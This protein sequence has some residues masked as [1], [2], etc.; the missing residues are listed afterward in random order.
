[1]SI[2]RSVELDHLPRRG[3]NINWIK[4]VGY[5][6]N[7]TYDDKT[8]LINILDYNPS[9]KKLLVSCNSEI[10]TIPYASLLS[11]K[12]ADVVSP[13]LSFEQWCIDNK[14]IDYL[15][16]WDYEK[17]GC[18][19]SDV[20]YKTTRQYYFKCPNLN[21]SHKSRKHGINHCTNENSRMDCVECGSIGQYIVDMYGE[22]NLYKIWSSENNESPYNVWK[23]TNKKYIFNCLDCGEEKLISPNK[24]SANGIRCSL[25]GDGFSYPNK[26]LYSF[27]RQLNVEFETEKSFKWSCDKRYDTYIALLMSEIIIENHGMQHYQD[28]WHD[29]E[30]TNENDKLKRDLALANG[31]KHYIELD[32]RKSELEWIKNSIMN[33]E[34]PKLLGFKEEDID[35]VECN[36]Y[37]TESKV[38]YVCE[39]WE[40]GKFVYMKDLIK[41]LGIGHNTL[42]RYLKRGADNDWCDYNPEKERKKGLIMGET[43]NCKKVQI[44]KDGIVIGEYPSAMDLARKSLNDFGVKIN[45]KGIS[46]VCKGIQS[47]HMGFSFKYV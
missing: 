21:P 5:T 23:S 24:F 20:S 16:R 7:A 17:N 19:P 25:C 40:S 31:I 18:S 6:I 39:M 12:I 26:F 34:L 38:R 10:S 15:D 33:S 11:C 27:I 30:D 9:T 8:Y 3:K 45:N 2:N 28:A 44:L 13:H 47:T 1:M 36:R 37:A 29:Y 35:W 14:R 32:C 41:H 4:S 46:A 42:T 22:E 43:A